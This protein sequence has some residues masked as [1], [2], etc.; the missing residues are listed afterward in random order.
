MPVHGNHYVAWQPRQFADYPEPGLHGQPQR[1]RPGRWVWDEK[2]PRFIGE[3]FFSTGNHP[4][5]R[6]SA[7]RRPSQARPA[8]LHAVRA[9]AADASA[10]LPLGRLRRLGLLLRPRRRRR[11]PVRLLSPRAVL[12]RQWDWT[13]GSGQPVKRT[14]AIFN[15]T[16]Y[17]DPIDFT[18]Y[19]GRR[20]QEGGG[21]DE[22]V[23]ASPPGTASGVRG[24]AADAPGRR[25]A[26]PR[27]S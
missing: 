27:G 9:D 21:G 14:L 1:R 26:G 24:D 5:G 2:R 12:C 7:A 15:D 19:A 8:T 4:T 3:D 17:A 11:Q 25:D 13:F 16:H 20:R 22:G 18:W 23:H 10:G 6:R